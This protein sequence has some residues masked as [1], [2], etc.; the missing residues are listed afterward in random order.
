MSFT[1]R[2]Y[3]HCRFLK[4]DLK[5]PFSRQFAF[6]DSGKIRETAK[7]GHGL[8]DES[9]RLALDQAIKIGRGG[10]WLNLTDKQY[11]TLK[12][13]FNRG[14]SGIGMIWGCAGLGLLLGGVFANWLG[15]RLSYSGYK[16]VVFIDFVVHGTAYV[17][18]SRAQRFDPALLFIFLSRFIMAVNSV[19]NYSYLLRTVANRY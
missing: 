10:I 4:W 8:L 18:F 1:Y 3:W 19:L 5:T 7:L 17:L 11:K 9:S 15:R 2:D 14:A 13:N 12:S 6:R 16:L